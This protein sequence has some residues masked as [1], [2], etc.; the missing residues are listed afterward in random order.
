[1]Q[2]VNKLDWNITNIHVINFISC[3]KQYV[4]FKQQTFCCLYLLEYEGEYLE[5]YLT[6]ILP[7]SFFFFVVFRYI[8]RDRIFSSTDS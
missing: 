7:N 3:I 4:S 2:D 6:L 1:M 8:A 5:M